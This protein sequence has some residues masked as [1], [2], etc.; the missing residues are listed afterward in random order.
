M[1][2]ARVDL[3][4]ED[5]G[6]EEFIR[7]VVVRMAKEVQIGVSVQVRSARGGHGRAIAELRAYQGIVNAGQARLPDIFVVAINGNCA[8]PNQARQDVASSVDTSLAGL[9]VI[10]C[11][12]PH[13]ERWYLAD[14]LSFHKVVGYKPTVAGGKCERAYYK[15]ALKEAC[16]RGGN[17]LTLGGIEFASD[18]VAAMD[19]YRAGKAEPGLAHFVEEMRSALQALRA[20]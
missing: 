14:P 15:Q 13:I 8:A 6:H 17:I 11:P 20:H 19:F 5:R 2:S 16:L 3:F 1:N 9:T 4:V 10:A 7:A 12:D 18:L